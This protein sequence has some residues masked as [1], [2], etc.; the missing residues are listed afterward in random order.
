[1]EF[2]V[3]SELCESSVTT[4]SDSGMREICD[5][6]GSIILGIATQLYPGSARKNSSSDHLMKGI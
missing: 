3:V 5:G 1:V 6:A 2:A 4:K